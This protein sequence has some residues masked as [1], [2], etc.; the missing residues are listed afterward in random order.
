MDHL[1]KRNGRHGTDAILFA[2][3]AK[4]PVYPSRLEHPRDAGG[5]Y[6]DTVQN[7]CDSDE[8]CTIL[9]T[10][11]ASAPEYRQG[12]QDVA[13]TALVDRVIAGVPLA[14]H[15]T[16]LVFAEES[17]YPELFSDP[18][19]AAVAPTLERG[20]QDE[21]RQLG[22]P[23]AYVPSGNRA[24]IALRKELAD[25]SSMTLELSGVIREYQANP[26]A[27]MQDRLAQAVARLRP[28][29]LGLQEA[30]FSMVGDDIDAYSDLKKHLAKTRHLALELNAGVREFL[31]VPC[32]DLE[33]AMYRLLDRYSDL[34]NVLEREQAGIP[35]DSA[36]PTP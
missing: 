17:D 26:S 3:S 21:N 7:L 19:I 13:R 16:V 35:K 1:I 23:V 8:Q 29:Y 4:D 24:D 2:M 36:G 10:L 6:A 18:V 31:G 34:L 30:H 11:D 22:D 28:I 20:I 5:R 32:R 12:I 15:V 25:A 33:K 27:G 14:D 9:L